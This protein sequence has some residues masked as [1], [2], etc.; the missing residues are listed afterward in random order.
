[1][2]I[3]RAEGIGFSSKFLVRAGT[4]TWLDFQLDLASPDSY[5]ASSKQ[6]QIARKSEHLSD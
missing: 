2:K 5:G 3:V 6:K 1:M 4:S